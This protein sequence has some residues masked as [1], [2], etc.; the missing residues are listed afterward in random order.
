MRIDAAVAPVFP[1]GVRRQ[2]R[3]SCYSHLTGALAG[4]VGTAVLLAVAR[5]TTGVALSL[6][7][8][9]SMVFMFTAS[10]L[11]HGFKQTEDSQS[12]WR[13][14]DHL[15]IFFMIAGSYTPICWLH[16]QG[17]WRWSILGTQWG[18]VLLGL[19]FKLFF[20]RAPRW[21]TAAIYVIM[22]WVLVIPMQRLLAS[23]DAAETALLLSGGIAYTL[24][25]VIYALKRPNPWPGLFGFHEIF[26]IAV[27]IGAALHYAAIFHMIA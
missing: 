19:V 24:G 10:A 16:L 18:F 27:V 26:H 7:Y 22:G 1:G 21:I 12:L 23:W 4:L 5:D 17:A 11:Y 3:F 25:A 13:R 6:V 20:I 9:V 14:L 2:E 8:G 15:A